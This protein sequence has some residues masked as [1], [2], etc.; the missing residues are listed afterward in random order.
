MVKYT[1]D[2]PTGLCGAY[3][4]KT[5]PIWALLEVWGTTDGIFPEPPHYSSLSFNFVHFHHLLSLR[6]TFR[7]STDT[8]AILSVRHRFTR[9]LYCRSYAG[10]IQHLAPLF[11]LWHFLVLTRFGRES[12]KRNST[13]G[14]AHYAIQRSVEALVFVL[15]LQLLYEGNL[16]MFITIGRGTKL[17]QLRGKPFKFQQYFQYYNRSEMNLSSWTRIK[18]NNN[19]YKLINDCRFILLLILVFLQNFKCFYLSISKC[20]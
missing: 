3:A 20:G 5:T 19:H 2:L 12:I 11:G 8:L 14:G 9:S 13:A 4:R 15:Q 17:N 16:T 6:Y 10:P 7:L 18:K 1:S